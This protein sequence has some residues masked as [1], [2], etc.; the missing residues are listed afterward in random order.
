MTAVTKI[1]IFYQIKFDASKEGNGMNMISKYT[2]HTTLEYIKIQNTLINGAQ[3]GGNLSPF[4][5]TA[6][7]YNSEKVL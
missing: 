5:L 6:I 1:D 4:V 2:T 7:R 3:D